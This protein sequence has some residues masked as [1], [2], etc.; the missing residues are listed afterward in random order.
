MNV[1]TMLSADERLT[2]LLRACGHRIYFASGPGRT[3]AQI[4]ALLDQRDGLSQLEVQQA[5]GIQSGSISELISKLELKGLVCRGRDEADR[6]RVTLRL[7]D[8]GRRAA[9]RHGV[10]SDAVI[11]YANLSDEDKAR[12]AALLEKVIEG[13]KEEGVPV[14][15]LFARRAEHR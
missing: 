9:V 15:E 6:R 4:L 2:L 8:E 13:W 10:E 5:L 1:D 11:R 7:T 3:Q 12:L 14:C